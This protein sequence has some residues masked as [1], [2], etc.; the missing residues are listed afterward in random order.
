MS[1]SWFTQLKCKSTI[2]ILLPPLYLEHRLLTVM[3][4]YT[5]INLHG[6]LKSSS[7]VCVHTHTHTHELFKARLCSGFR[8]REREYSY[9]RGI[10]VI[11]EV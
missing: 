6:I 2:A 3:V 5:F 1:P 4:R 7:P 8:A 10:S 11:T 9:E